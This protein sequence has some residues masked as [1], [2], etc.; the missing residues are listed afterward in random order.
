[1]RHF[2]HAMRLSPLDPEAGH[3]LAGKT[4]A[5]LLIN[6]PQNALET[7]R[8]AMAAMPNSTSPLRAAIFALCALGRTGEARKVGR[9]LVRL[10]PAFRVG[11][12]EEVQPFR[13]AAFSRRYIE[14]LRTAGLP[15]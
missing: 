8:H 2:D 4:F 7:S 6:R 1:L 3:T 9:E 13:D 11:A 15:E 5:H 10:N 14:S 12:F